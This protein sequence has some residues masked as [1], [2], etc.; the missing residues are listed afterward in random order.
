MNK[1]EVLAK[2]QEEILEISSLI[3]QDQN[4]VNSHSILLA[5]INGLSTMAEHAIKTLDDPND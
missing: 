2:L 3:W 4:D 1:E 5:Y